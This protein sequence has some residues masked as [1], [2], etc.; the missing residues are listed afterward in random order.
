[1]QPKLLGGDVYCHYRDP[2]S[3]LVRRLQRGMRRHQTA[4]N[5]VDTELGKGIGGDVSELKERDMFGI[6]WSGAILFQQS[7]TGAHAVATGSAEAAKG[8]AEV[9]T[10]SAEVATGSAETA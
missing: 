7:I 9:A 8:S 2:L 5:D 3:S 1:M 4:G 6:A 10:G